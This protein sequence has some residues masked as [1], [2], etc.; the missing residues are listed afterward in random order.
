MVANTFL[1]VTN[2]NAADSEVVPLR[3]YRRAE[4]RQNGSA[5]KSAMNIVPFRLR[6]SQRQKLPVIVHSSPAQVRF[7][8]ELRRLAYG[9]G[10]FALGILAHMAWLDAWS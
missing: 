3:S 10:M 6:H 4:K 8:L 1:T 5:F 7:R 9:A 2:A